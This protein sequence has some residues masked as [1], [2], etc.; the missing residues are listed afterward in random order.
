MPTSYDVSFGVTADSEGV[1]P[2]CYTYYGIEVGGLPHLYSLP[3]DTTYLEFNLGQDEYGNNMTQLLLSPLPISYPFIEYNIGSD[4]DATITREDRNNNIFSITFQRNDP[5]PILT[6]YLYFSVATSFSFYDPDPKNNPVP[7]L[8][9]YPD[10]L[11]K[12]Y[13]LIIDNISVQ[14]I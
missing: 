9:K 4:K 7:F 8:Q 3:V 12:G 11:I 13:S 10:E 14:I 6:K 5:M 1:S 2:I